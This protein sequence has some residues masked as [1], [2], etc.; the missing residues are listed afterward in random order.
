MKVHFYCTNHW[1]SHKYTK[2][3]VCG[4]N[5]IQIKICT[6]SGDR[7]A[8]VAGV[9][10]VVDFFTVVLDF[11][12]VVVET[13]MVV[14]DSLEVVLDSSVFAFARPVMAEVTADSASIV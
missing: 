12:T 9:L 5:K 2:I 13:L 8:V 3:R 11:L 7:A 1:R 14:V 10:V 6:P 4:Y